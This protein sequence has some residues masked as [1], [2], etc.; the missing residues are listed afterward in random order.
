MS[1]AA[2]A[3]RSLRTPSLEN[4]LIALCLSGSVALL[5]AGLAC[6]RRRRRRR[7]RASGRS[8]FS[9]FSLTLAGQWIV[10]GSTLPEAPDRRDLPRLAGAGVGIQH[11]YGLGWTQGAPFVVGYCSCSSPPN[12]APSSARG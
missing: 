5:V 2:S 6:R 11:Y 10:S 3:N 1:Y 8:S 12:F 9:A 4:A 7:R